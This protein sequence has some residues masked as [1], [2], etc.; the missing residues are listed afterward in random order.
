MSEWIDKEFMP[1][2]R[3]R[4]KAAHSLL[5]GELQSMGVPYLERPAALYVWVDLRKVKSC[6]D[7]TEGVSDIFLY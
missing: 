7:I 2:N 3:C 1:E 6:K 5:K 4:L